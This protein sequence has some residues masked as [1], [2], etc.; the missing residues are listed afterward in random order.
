MSLQIQPELIYF[1]QERRAGSHLIKIG[2]TGDCPYL[3]LEQLRREKRKVA[4]YSR[5]ELL[6]VIEIPP[7]KNQLSSQA[8]LHLQ[9]QFESLRDNGDWFRPGSE[10]VNYIREHSGLHICNSSC[11]DGSVIYEEIQARQDSAMKAFASAI[12]GTCGGDKTP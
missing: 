11:P 2:R 4:P 3:R 12:G 1:I 7:S 9:N 8:K 5:F 6:G 10:F